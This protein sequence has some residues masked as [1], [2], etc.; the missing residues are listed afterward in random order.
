MPTST[1]IPPARTARDRSRLDTR[2]RLMERGAELFSSGGVAGTRASD[3]AAAA[4]VAVGTL[5]FHFGDKTGLLDAILL[6]GVAE[7]RDR[8]EEVRNREFSDLQAAF[9]TYSETL[10]T[11]VEEHPHLG[12]VLFSRELGSSESGRRILELGFAMQEEEFAELAARGIGRPDL[13][14]AVAARALVGMFREVLC[15]WC[16][17]RSRASREDVINSLAQ[18]RLSAFVA[19]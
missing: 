1:P 9:H 6:E 13:N 3:I 8:L 10:V 16:E 19:P 17:D 7:M 5:Y 2:R 12:G 15:W 4:G 11:F 14:H 18:L